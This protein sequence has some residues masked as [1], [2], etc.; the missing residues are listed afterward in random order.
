MGNP[1]SVSAYRFLHGARGRRKE[2][3]VERIKII[4]I[5]MSQIAF[6]VAAI[7]LSSGCQSKLTKEARAGINCVS[8]NTEVPIPSD[9]SYG[10]DEASGTWWGVVISLAGLPEKVTKGRAINALMRKNNIDLGRIIVTQFKEQLETKHVFPSIVETNEDATFTLEIWSY[11][12]MWDSRGVSWP[13]YP[14]KPVL[15]VDVHLK[16]P[17]GTLIW[18]KRAETYDNT[19]EVDAYMYDEYIENPSLL[20]KGFEQAASKIVGQFLENIEAD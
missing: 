7:S 2:C 10:N 5:R 12:L 20:R 1:R 17:D 4:L 9:M 19:S 13:P 15:T 16:K 6:V 3:K 14:L 8:I 18:K 11:G